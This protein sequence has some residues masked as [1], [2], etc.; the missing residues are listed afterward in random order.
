[1]TVIMWIFQYGFLGFYAAMVIQAIIA[2]I[3]SELILMFGGVTYMFIYWPVNL[4][5]GFD[6]ALLMTALVGG[7]GEL[8][9]A[10]AGFYIARIVGRPVV[11]KWEEAA[12]AR[13]G[14][15]NAEKLGRVE[16]AI[17]LTLGD[18]VTIA[19]NWLERWGAVA[20]LLMRLA[21]PIPFDAVSYGAGLT[22]IKFKPFIAATAV[23]SFPRALMY[24]YIGKR[25]YES[26]VLIPQAL[27]ALFF[28][29][30]NPLAQI[31]IYN[32]LVGNPLMSNPY[33]IF[34]VVAAAILASLYFSYE[35]IRRRHLRGHQKWRQG[36]HP[37][38]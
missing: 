22:K 16:R 14:N 32:Y 38:R 3:P 28:L 19:D 12:R 27:R 37:Q 35:I 18:A 23:G 17:I 30:E 33:T 7:V 15:P 10:V 8:T 5:K 6:Y 2:V 9:G 11:A 29:T 13:N 21:P 1:M 24:A 4:V 26:F 20:V 34:F 36:V 31:V 25:T